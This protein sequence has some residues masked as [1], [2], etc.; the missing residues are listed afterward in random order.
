MTT[1]LSAMT[2]LSAFRD[3]V[4]GAHSR[5]HPGHGPFTTEQ[6]DTLLMQAFLASDQGTMSRRVNLVQMRIDGEQYTIGFN[7]ERYAVTVR[8]GSQVG[9][10]VA[11]I[12]R[13]TTP[14]E[15]RG[16]FEALKAPDACRYHPG[17]TA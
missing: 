1:S 13:S 4:R 11:V 15:I 2:T 8:R 14:D 3:F 12:D 6:L 5:N 10:I 16:I 7:A 17:R 9:H